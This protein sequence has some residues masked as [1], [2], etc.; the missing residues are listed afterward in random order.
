[1]DGMKRDPRTYSIIG[2]AMEVHRILGPGFLEP[3]YHDALLI[4]FQKR[5][6]PH[7]HEVS[8][9]IVYKGVQLRTSYRADFICH[10]DVLVEIKAISNLTAHDDAQLLHYL[11]A[12]GIEIGLLINFGTGSLEYRRLVS[13]RNA[14]S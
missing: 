5:N 6:I 14:D 1:M 12:T 10:N 13:T 3:T 11:R 9:P 2:A 7:A 4:E 8:V